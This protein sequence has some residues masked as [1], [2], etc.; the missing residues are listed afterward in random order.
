MIL[1]SFI[2]DN[3]VFLCMKIM[4][5]V[6]VVG[7]Y[8]GFLTTFSIGPS[9]LFLLRARAMQEGTEKKISATTGFIGGQLMMFISL[10]YTPLHLAL[11]RPYTII[12]IALPYL[13]FHFF[14]KNHKELNYGY[15]KPNSIRNFSI[16]TL[17]FNNLIFQLLNPPFLPSS[18][19]IRLVKID[20][21]RWNNKLLFLTSSFGGWLIGY[22]FLT[23]WIRFLL[24]CIKKN[25]WI[26]SNGPIKYI[27]S[28]FRLISVSEILIVLLFITCLYYL[29]RAPSGFVIKE[30]SEIKERNDKKRK[31]DAEKTWETAET[32]Q[33]QKMSA[34]EFFFP[35]KKKFGIQ[36]S[37]ATILF[38]YKRWNR[39]MRYI[40]N[41][42]FENFVRNDISQFFFSICKNDEKE[43]MC[44]SY[45]SNLSTFLK[46]MQTKMPLLTIQNTSLYNSLTSP[47]DNEEKIKIL[48]NEFFN[49]AKVI[50]KEFFLPNRVEK[51]IRLSNDETQKKYLPKIYDPLLNGPCRG[52]IRKSFSPSIKN[53]TYKKNKILINKIH[54]ILLNTINSNNREFEQKLDRFYIK[55][56]LTEI[57]FFLNLIN[58]FSGKSLSNLNFEALYLFRKHKQVKTD[59]EEKKRK[60]QFLFDTIRPD[61]NDKT[62]V[63]RKKCIGIREINKKVPRWSYKLIDELQQLD[64]KN[65]SDSYS[66]RS[67]KAKRVVIYTNNSEN[68][69]TYSNTNE[70]ADN[71]EN[72]KELALIRYSQQPDFRRDIIKGSIRAQRRKIIV[73]KFC[74]RNVHSPLFLDKIEKAPFFSVDIFEPMKIFF[75]FKNW[76]RKTAKLQIFDY[77]EKKTKESEKEEED[78]RKKK[79]KDEKRRIEI[80]EA[81]D[82]IIFAQ[83]IRG[84]LLITQS[85]LRKYIILPSL[86][87]TKN[88]AR[89]V[90]FQFPEWSEDFRDW[91]REMYIKCTYNG[92]ELSETEFP[93]KW[94][95]DG[96]Q[97]KVLFPFR[98]K[99]W[100]RSKQRPPEKHKDRMKKIKP[101]FCFLTITGMEVEFPFSNYPHNRVLF[102]DPIFKELKKKKKKINFFFFRVLAVLNERT[103]VFRN[104]LKDFIKA[105]KDFI[106]ASTDKVKWIIKRIDKSFL[107]LNE[108]GKKLS[109]FLFLLKNK[110]ELSQ[111]E[112]D[113]TMNKSNPM[114]SE[115]DIQIKPINCK[116]S[117]LKV[118]EKKIKNV[119]DKRK[120]IEKKILKKIN[121]KGFIR[122]DINISSN[123]TTYVVKKLKL[124]QKKG[125]LQKLDKKL[126]RKNAQLARKLHFFF[127]KKRL[128]IDIF[129]YIISI[130]II[131][132]QLFLDS[133]NIIKRYIYNNDEN[134]K[135]IIELSNIIKKNSNIRGKNSQN[136]PFCLSQA[137]V[138]YK[139]SQNQII[140]VYKYNLRSVFEY[141]RRSFFL[142]N[143][144][145]DSSFGVD[146]LCYPKLKDKAPP[147]SVMNPR[148]KWTDWLKGHSQYDLSQNRWFRLGPQKWR[149]K[150]TEHCLVENKD[151]TNCDSYEKK[152][153]I[154]YKKEQVNSL[155]NKK[156]K[157]KKQ[158]NKRSYESINYV[159]KTGDYRYGYK[160]PFQT[161]KKK[162]ISYNYT[163]TRKQKLFDIMN[164]RAVTNY[165]AGDKII[166]MK[167]NRDRKFFDWRGMN[168]QMQNIS[169]SNPERFLFSKF[170]IFYN[171][172]MSN[173]W[174]IPIQLVFF[175]FNVNK[176]VRDNKN[177]TEKKKLIAIFRLSKKKKKSLEFELETRNKKKK[178]SGRPVD[179]ESSLSNQEKDI[180]QDSEDS[181]GSNHKDKETKSKTK[182]EKE[183]NFLLRKFLGFQLNR[184]G[185]FNQKI[186]NNVRV[187]CL[188]VRLINLKEIV[189]TS[190]Q[191]GEL[192]LDLMLIKNEKDLPLTGLGEN[193]NEQ[194]LR[195]A[196]L[197]VEPVRLSRKN[198]EQFIMYQTIGPSLI[199]KSKRQIN[200][201]YPEKGRGNKK[202]FE[203][204]IP[205]NQKIRENKEK[206]H[207]DLPVPENIL[208]T[209]RCR[210]LRILICLNP[211]NQNRVERKTT[212]CKEN[213]VNNSYQVFAKNTNFDREKKKLMNFKFFLWPI[214]R[215]EDLGCINRYWFNTNNGS[216]F[217]I[218]RIHMYPRLKMP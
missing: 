16:P 127:K 120:K 154:L 183:L 155:T 140:N 90:L 38:D 94:L 163:K 122:S 19:L 91:R 186:I 139:L 114:F 173:P 143:E 203:K 144:L 6:V 217:S 55:T 166:D 93:Q 20:M 34:E 66:I 157:L 97:I 41:Y 193:N 205:K 49:R 8:Y 189:I 172:Y 85:F 198:D 176:K 202:T 175:D 43:R 123:K 51:R 213:K 57:C 215:L 39:P 71:T 142:K 184:K 199:H 4:N 101:D 119:N 25:N 48:S 73:W 110:Y 65:E 146:K 56:L 70:D 132:L 149:D 26:K 44:F 212:F 138:F 179:I 130:P 136:D 207:S 188:L 204:Y 151:L 174:I 131:I 87:I 88:I 153:L 68:D 116:N 52:R 162:M 11:G 180:Q 216:N 27:M 99:P 211:R 40:K 165:I 106:N 187:Y 77:T 35:K 53:E 18:M 164:D 15:K 160:S 206:K 81:W 28:L 58:T 96:I 115:S 152:T 117:S 1:Q 210:E 67:R 47:N 125:I 14:A 12:V 80:A 45:P 7:L 128:S 82:S 17:F 168:T 126:Q 95:T 103:E 214:Y 23:K 46:I 197:I 177:I 30:L 86:I 135:S 113:S 200:Q 182:I 64:E 124:Q 61:L 98:L 137:Y 195:K 111:R 191:R 159:N 147:D 145:K 84:F 190:I 158:Y 54:S 72:K 74:Q 2:L 170:V 167:K 10:Y 75:M 118:K 37:L 209:R 192:S 31:I 208:V 133:K 105:S 102:F 121:K 109:N 218:V 185:P 196:M 92:V 148:I 104:V 178:E 63:N 9:Y 21:F 22:S 50:D 32:K 3:L 171:L 24:V 141:Q 33:A 89:L 169:V 76:M 36:K 107:F 78:K 112:K 129:L 62:V 100:H 134:A 69:D 83:V 194:F 161:N 5:S 181:Y 42:Q 59:V 60:I 201:N 108:K 29:S 156:K 13:F 79:E 150:I